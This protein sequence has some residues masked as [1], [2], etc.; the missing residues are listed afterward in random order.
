[1]VRPMSDRTRKFFGVTAMV[2]FTVF[3]LWFAVTVAIMRLP[4]T[5]LGLQLAFYFVVA[6]IWFAVCAAIIWWMRPRHA[7]QTEKAPGS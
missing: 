7:Q 1:M 2:A 4:G 5:A 6:A 3:Y